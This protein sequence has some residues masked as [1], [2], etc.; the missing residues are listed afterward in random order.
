MHR[1]PSTAPIIALSPPRDRWHSLDTGRALFQDHGSGTPMHRGAG[2]LPMRR[3]NRALQSGARRVGGPVAFSL[4]LL[5]ALRSWAGAA[6]WPASASFRTEVFPLLAR[7][8]SECHF[9]GMNQ[10]GVAFDEFRSDDEPL[11]RPRLWSTALRYVRAG[12]MP[13]AGWPRPS[14]EER[15]RLENWIKFTAFAIDPHD[16]DPGRVTIRRLNR[17][18]YRNTIRDLM[19]VDFDADAAFPPD[20]TGHGFDNLGDVL[21][22]SPMLLEKYLAAARSIVATATAPTAPAERVIPGRSLAGSATRAPGESGPDSLSLSCHQAGSVSYRFSAEDAGHYRLILHLTAT[23]RYADGSR[24]A[25]VC[26]LVFKVDGRALLQRDFMGEG[27]KPLR[28]DLEQRWPSGV[29]EL[30]LEWQPLPG[31]RAPVTIGLDAVTVRGPLEERYWTRNAH[32]ARFFTRPAPPGPTERRAYAR[33]VLLSFARKA[34]R[35]PV[36]D[37]TVDRLVALAEGTSRQPGQTFEGGIAQAMVAV[38]SS[39]RFLFREEGVEP[40]RAG[41][42]HPFIDEHALAA[43]LSYFLWSSMPDA[44]L[45]RLADEGGLRKDLPA[46]VRRMIVDPRA[47]ALTEHFTGQWLQARDIETVSIDARAVLAREGGPEPG[48][49]QVVSVSLTGALRSAMRR[50]T[51]QVFEY[52]VPGRSESARADRQRLHLPE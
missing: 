30:T 11:T 17:V 49:G 13:P 1:W 4:L 50:E 45:M 10:G 38:L 26:R 44:L 34:Y 24:D 3:L 40:V 9:D 41:H 31:E 25:G 52:I 14:P 19:G 32:S 47:R 33:E 37:T 27:G 28:Y 35:R 22:L 18:E 2:Q 7:Y 20:D 42:L 46:Q 48:P 16:P 6:G 29:H 51:E 21:T 39:P 43:R 36:D 12:L 8:C 23:R 15:K 5:L